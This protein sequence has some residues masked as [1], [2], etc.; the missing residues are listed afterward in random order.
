ML[1]AILCCLLLSVV[2]IL[3]TFYRVSRRTSDCQPPLLG[4]LP[5]IVLD[6]FMCITDHHDNWLVAAAAGRMF[7]ER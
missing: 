5:L 4:R 2:N 1:C 3:Y 6:L 7:S